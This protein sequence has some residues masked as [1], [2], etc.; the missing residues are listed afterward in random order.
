[1]HDFEFK[2]KHAMNFLDDGNKVKVVVMFKG[3]EMAYQDQ[4]KTLIQKFVEKTE[5]FAKVEGEIKM[6]GRNMSVILVPARAKVK[7][8]K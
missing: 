8:L 3:R 2:V 5:E 7:K 6:E 1:V 4:G